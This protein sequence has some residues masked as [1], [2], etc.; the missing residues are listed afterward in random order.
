MLVLSTDVNVP[1][2]LCPSLFTDTIV[3]I[4]DWLVSIGGASGFPTTAASRGSGGG[5]AGGSVS[6]GVGVEIPHT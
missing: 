4:E 2:L 5:G 6:S 1:V 3:V